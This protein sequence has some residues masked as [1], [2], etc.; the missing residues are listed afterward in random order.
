MRYRMGDATFPNKFFCEKSSIERIGM[1]MISL[2]VGYLLLLGG[3]LMVI[4]SIFSL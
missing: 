4:V 3:E 1:R 2:F